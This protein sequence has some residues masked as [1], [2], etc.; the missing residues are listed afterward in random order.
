MK[1]FDH[2]IYTACEETKILVLEEYCLPEHV[3]KL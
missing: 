2:G 3:W 1:K